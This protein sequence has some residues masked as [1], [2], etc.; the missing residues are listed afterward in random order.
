M[1]DVV[2]CH[3]R[4]PMTS[5]LVRQAL[6][7]WL[8]EPER[9][10]LSDQLCPLGEQRLIGSHTLVSFG[11]GLVLQL[12]GCQQTTRLWVHEMGVGDVLLA[13]GLGYCLESLGSHR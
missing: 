9:A 5:R 12:L 4:Q 8:Q 6:S 7:C 2:L 1:G 13:N 3:A 10:G 11:S